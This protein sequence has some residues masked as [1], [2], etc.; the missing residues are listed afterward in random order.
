MRKFL[1]S[2]ILASLPALGASGAMA[3]SSA[4]I[5][6]YGF[7]QIGQSRISGSSSD[8]QSYYFG[9]FGGSYSFGNYGG[10]DIGLDLGVMGFGSLDSGSNPPAVT[11]GAVTFGFGS[12]KVSVGAPRAAYDMAALPFMGSTG[13]G[14]LGAEFYLY[15]LSVNDLARINIASDV[16]SY[17][18]RYDGMFSGTH[19]AAS[20]NRIAQGG[21]SL[22]TY[23]VAAMYQMGNI[24]LYGGTE[25]SKGTG[26]SD[27]QL[28]L[29]GATYDYG[30]GTAGLAVSY[31]NV[32][33]SM[34]S[35]ATQVR[36][37]VNYDVTD[38]LKLTANAWGITQGSS[39][40]IRAYGIGA[41]YKVF[42]NA[43]IEAGYM[44]FDSSSGSPGDVTSIALN[45]S[46]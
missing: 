22:D 19:V 17:G 3:Q 31:G 2:T 10:V 4:G 33:F 45:W 18:L 15:G 23:G 16:Q 42:S 7:V 30:K 20:W 44:R 38:R 13:N 5:T 28:S 1:L 39:D 6:T 29:I 40:N 11:F 37:F 35:N 27:L 32:L 24:G 25:Y 26:T 36:G 34:V 43:S 14:L 21:D 12:N 9:D 41:D 46:F 8:T